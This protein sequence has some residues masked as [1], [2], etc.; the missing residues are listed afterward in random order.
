MKKKKLLILPLILIIA[1]AFSNNI[2]LNCKSEKKNSALTITSKAF[3]EGEIIPAKYTCDAENISPEISWTKGPDK[4]KTY[5]LICDDPDAPSKVWVHWV[6]YNIP[7]DVTELT[8]KF[9]TDSIYKNIENGINDFGTLGYSGPC[10]P[11]GTHHYKFKIY[12]LDCNLNLKAASTKA[13]L[14]AAMKDHIIANGMLTGL[15]KRM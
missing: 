7:A 14:E 10:P 13:Q 2:F 12:A 4:T 1:F 3:A 6:V 5:A 8:E 9:P 11:S 15:Y